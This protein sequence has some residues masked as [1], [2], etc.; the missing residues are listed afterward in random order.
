MLHLIQHHFTK[1]SAAM[2]I[3]LSVVFACL[4]AV[5]PT[6]LSQ[7]SNDVLLKE[8]W[9]D[10][11]LLRDTIAR[12]DT[13]KTK[14]YQPKISGVI[15]CHYLN[16]IN[17][18]GDSIRDPD[19]FR[20]FR[21]RLNAKGKI[22][23]F[24]SYELMIDPRSPEHGGLLRDAFIEIQFLSNQKLRIGKQKT[25][26]GWENR[27]SVTELYTVNRAE[28]SDFVARGENLRDIGIGLIGQVPLNKSLRIENAFTFTNGTRHDVTGPYDFNTKKAL[29]GRVGLRYLKDDLEMRIGG[30]FGYGGLRYLGD[31][32]ETP[33][34]DVYADFNRMGADVQMDHRY[35]FMAAEYG[36]GTDMAG[37]TL[38]GEPVG[39]SAQ[40]AIKAARNAGPLVRYDAGDDEYKRLT[41][42]LFYGLPKDNLQVLINYEF[43][44]QIMDIPEGHDDRL[45]IQLQVS[46]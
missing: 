43:R 36:M 4:L 18:N 44:K 27:K 7:N 13:V 5:S 8:S 26:F 24:I 22:N 29:W 40:L 46:F 20:I 9:M 37:D 12:G 1:Q 3:R 10:A 41:I 38:Y 2:I 31:T 23:P 6:A 21:A 33:T 14:K 32:I 45:Y 28:Y 11:M 35:F 25:Q 19:G 15:T 42:G 16:E 39:Y 30:S 17:T 34:D